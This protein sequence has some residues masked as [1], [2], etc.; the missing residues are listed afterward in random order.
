MIGGEVY[1]VPDYGF[2]VTFYVQGP[3]VIYVNIGGYSWSRGPD[4]SV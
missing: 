1:L 3:G 2:T 4:Y